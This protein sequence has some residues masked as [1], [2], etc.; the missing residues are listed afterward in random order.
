MVHV[1]ATRRGYYYK[2][3]KNG[4]KKRISEKEYLKK[5]NKKIYGGGGINKNNF[6][7]V[8]LITDN[9]TEGLIWKVTYKNK[10]YVFKEFLK[11]S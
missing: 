11:L 7:N 1:Y 6:S 8:S 2:T 3:Y 5:R 10:D 4:S 9:S